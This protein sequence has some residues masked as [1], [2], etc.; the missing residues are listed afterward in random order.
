MKFIKTPNKICHYEVR[1]KDSY[2]GNIY[3]LG[4]DHTPTFS[5]LAYLNPSQLREVANFLDT[6]T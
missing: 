3:S 1:D 5:C 4:K 2:I 6:L